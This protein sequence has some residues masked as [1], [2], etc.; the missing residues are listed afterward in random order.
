MVKK[1]KR[2]S[3]RIWGSAYD[4]RNKDMIKW[5]WICEICGQE[6]LS[7]KKAQN[8]THT[9]EYREVNTGYYQMTEVET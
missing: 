3:A 9:K 4:P 1:G 5:S 8:C 2:V 6:Y 7:K